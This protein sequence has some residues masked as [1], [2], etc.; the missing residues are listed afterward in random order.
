[1]TTAVRSFGLSLPDYPWEAM[2]PYLAKAAEHPDG[3]VNLSIGT[4]VDRTPQVIQ[5]ALRAAA[6]APGYPTVHGTAGHRRLVCT[7]PRC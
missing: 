6:D 4:P 5:E 3:V 1:V 7:P 2:A